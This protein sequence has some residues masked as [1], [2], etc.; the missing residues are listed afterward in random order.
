MFKNL[1]ISGEIFVYFFNTNEDFVMKRNHNQFPIMY[2][3]NL[4]FKTSKV[5]LFGIQDSLEKMLFVQKE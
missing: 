5:V 3:A 4:A 2:I 1:K